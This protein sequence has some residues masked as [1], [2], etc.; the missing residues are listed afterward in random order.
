MSPFFMSLH[1][2]YVSV[3]LVAFSMNIVILQK[4]QMFLF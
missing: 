1:I 3:F 4:L 2:Y